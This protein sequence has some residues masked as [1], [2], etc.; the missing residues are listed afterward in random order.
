VARW[1]WNALRAPPHRPA[2]TLSARCPCL[3]CSSCCWRRV[4]S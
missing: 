2:C 4:S 1:R 3:S